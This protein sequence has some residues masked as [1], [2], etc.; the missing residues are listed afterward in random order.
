M[1]LKQVSIFLLV[2]TQQFVNESGGDTSITNSNSNFRSELPD[3]Q[4]FQRR[5]FTR[6]DV[7]YISHIIPPRE[8]VSSTVNIEFNSIDVSK[9]VGVTSTG[10]LY[11]Y[12]ETNESYS[13]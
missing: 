3:L 6:D 1:S 8:S 12:Q 10:H 5:A 2:S 11:L 9:T 7:G 4:R 13:S